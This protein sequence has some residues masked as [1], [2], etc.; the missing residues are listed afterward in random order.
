MSAVL[1]AIMYGKDRI[2]EQFAALT[3]RLPICVKLF[4]NLQIQFYLNNVTNLHQ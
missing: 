2:C 1:A 3:V 4:L